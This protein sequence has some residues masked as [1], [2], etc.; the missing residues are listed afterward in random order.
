MEVPLQGSTPTV[1]VKEGVNAALRFR[2][3]I[4]AGP[5]PG[6]RG[7][8]RGVVG[9]FDHAL[10]LCGDHDDLASMP[11]EHTPDEVVESHCTDKMGG[12]LDLEGGDCDPLAVEIDSIGPG[13]GA[14]FGRRFRSLVGDAPADPVW[15]VS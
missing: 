1:E 4:V 15:R 2:D 11:H 8:S 5:V 12:L 14:G 6:V 7:D 10:G 13:L 9:D 3:H